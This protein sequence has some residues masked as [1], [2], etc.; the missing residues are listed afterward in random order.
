MCMFS[1][2]RLWLYSTLILLSR[3]LVTELLS[4]DLGRLLEAGALEPQFVQYFAYQIL[5]RV[6]CAP[7]LSS[8][9][10]D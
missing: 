4:T 10:S 7:Y 3:Y 1:R 6:A 2:N 9:N 8:L 5:V